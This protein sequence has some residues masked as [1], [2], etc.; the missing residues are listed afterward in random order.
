MHHL[1]RLD[2]SFVQSFG[3]KTM[4]Q[5]D[6]DSIPF[7]ICEQSVRLLGFLRTRGYRALLREDQREKADVHYLGT[8]MRAFERCSTKPMG[9]HVQCQSSIGN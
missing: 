9:C 4:R 6:L 1:V 8:A 5:S 2:D 3:Q 7:E